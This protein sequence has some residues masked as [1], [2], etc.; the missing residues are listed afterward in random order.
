MIVAIVVVEK[1][2]SRANQMQGGWPALLSSAAEQAGPGKDHNRLS[3]NV[4]LLELPKETALLACVVREAQNYGI[5]HRVL[6][7][8][9]NPLEY[10]FPS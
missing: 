8:A 9:E 1:P 3:D 6:Y 10:S 7:F 4:W 5:P 2:A